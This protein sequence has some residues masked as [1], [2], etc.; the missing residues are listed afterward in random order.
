M[1]RSTGTSTWLDLSIT[2]TD[3][4]KAFYGGLFGWEFEDLGESFNHYHL[5]RN[6]D[7]L[8]GGLMNVSGMTCPAGDPLPPEWDVYLAVDDADAR[9][10]KA[11]A[12]GGMVIVP[13]DAISDS[14]RMSVI[15]DATG[16]SIGLWQAGDLEGYE[17]TGTPGSP[18]WFELMTHKYD[19]AVAFYTEVFD[20]QLVPMEEEMSGPDFRYATNGPGESASWGLC[21]ATGMMPEDATGWR[22]YLGV[23]SSDTAIARVEELGGRVLDG[24]TP[25]PFG[26]IATIADP[27]GATFQI[28]AMGEAAPEG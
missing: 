11:A 20:A 6:G 26:T 10:A 8:V 17:F 5:I 14:G 27:E 22:V 24:P 7:A 4:A 2:D 23:D 15:L 18:V 1:I 13:P 3:A 25:S 16:A 12:A 9:T 19:E 21:D 28:S